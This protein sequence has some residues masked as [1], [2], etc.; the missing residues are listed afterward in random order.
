MSGKS[1]RAIGTQASATNAMVKGM[2]PSRGRIAILNLGD[3][4]SLVLRAGS[5]SRQSDT[6]FHLDR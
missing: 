4:G 2:F 5:L 3:S 1:R 6:R